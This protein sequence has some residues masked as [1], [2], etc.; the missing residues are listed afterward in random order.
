MQH[1]GVAVHAVQELGEV[2]RVERYGNVRAVGFYGQV[3][4]EIADL[5]AR[6][7]CHIVLR[8][9]EAHEI[10]VLI[11]TRHEHRAVDSVLEQRFGNVHVRVE[12]LRHDLAV[13]D[14][15]AVDEPSRD[16]RRV[17]LDHEIVFVHIEPHDVVVAL[18]EPRDLHDR[19]NG[20]DNARRRGGGN[21]RFD[22]LGEPVTVERDRYYVVIVDLE[23][24]AFERGVLVVGAHR[25]RDLVHEILDVRDLGLE[26]LSISGNCSEE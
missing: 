2:P 24:H 5:A 12:V 21:E 15:L 7:H 16:R 19:A 6:A 8:D 26:I 13:I 10:V 23:K 18:D 3:L 14:E 20:N 25:E 17:E 22:A 1:D 9:V 11:R 4:F